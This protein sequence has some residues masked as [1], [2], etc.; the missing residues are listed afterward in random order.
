KR[1]S[2]WNDVIDRFKSRLSEWKAKAMS[3]GGRLTLVKS[4]LG[5]LPLYYFLLFRV[6]SSVISALERV[7]KKIL[8]RVIKSIYGSDG[9][10]EGSCVRWKWN[11]DDKGLFSVKVLS[12]YIVNVFAWRALLGRLPVRTELDK[13]GIDLDSL[14]CPGYD[15]VVESVYHCLALCENAINAWDRIFSWWRV[16]LVDLFTIKDFLL[17]NGSVSMPKEAK[18]LW[19]AQFGWLHI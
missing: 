5:S 17:H 6:L 7:R 11:V 1:V 16:G 4:V 3:F 9:G 2:A 8:L 18:A 15:N 19:S 13:K 14:L 12:R 10:F